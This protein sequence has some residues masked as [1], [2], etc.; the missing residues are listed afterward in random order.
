MVA[1][2]PM[3]IPEIHFHHMHIIPKQRKRL[4][5]TEGFIACKPNCSIQSYVPA[6]HPL[7]EFIPSKLAVSTYQAV[8]GA[9]RR[10]EDW[11]E[12]IDNVNPCIPGED[13]KS[14]IEPL[15]IWGKIY[16]QQIIPAESPI[17][18][19]QTKRVPVSDGHLA[20]VWISFEKP[21]SKE[22]IIHRWR[23]C[24]TIPQELKLPSAPDPFLYY[25]DE[26]DRPQT[27]LDRDLGHGMAI[28]IGRLKKDKIFDFQYTCLS[29]N[30]IRGAAGGA[31][32]L[33]ELAYAMGYLA[34]K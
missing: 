3:V 31:I 4:G 33:A 15:K 28:A 17:I 27:K 14:E 19:A 2:V 24:K 6:I 8:S 11:P 25:F 12:M 29:H 10:L 23:N 34:K 20:S 21:P 1:D 16:K 18:S 9:G 22:E 30:T 13:E 32:E 7:M 5:T 26:P